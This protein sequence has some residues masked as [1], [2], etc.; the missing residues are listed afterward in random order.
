MLR[1]LL[2]LPLFASSLAFAQLAITPATLP[3][4][5]LDTTY[6]A[7]PGAPPVVASF[8]FIRLSV[9]GSS[10]PF[11]F[12]LLTGLLPPGLF[13]TQFGDLHGVP[14][15][16]GQFDFVVRAVS[17]QQETV[18]QSYSLLVLPPFASAQIAV[19]G[20][21]FVLPAQCEVVDSPNVYST[22]GS[23][24][25]GLSVSS[26]S[27]TIF[28]VPTGPPGQSTFSW[29]CVGD[30]QARVDFIFNVLAMPQ[31]SFSGQVGSFFSQ[32]IVFTGGTAPFF[33]YRVVSGE[34]PPG[35][36]LDASSGALTGLPTAEGDYSV[37]VQ[38]FD[39]FEDSFQVAIDIS[40]G[41][42]LEFS[43]VPNVMFLDSNRDGPRVSQTVRVTSG[44]TSDSFSMVSSTTGGG[45]WLSA[46]P[47]RGSTPAVVRI[48]ADPS[49]LPA[50]PYR[51][52]VDVRSAGIDGPS[53]QVQI[54]V[55]FRVVDSGPELSVAPR[56]IQASFRQGASPQQR[57]LD[58]VGAGAS[59]ILFSIDVSTENGGGWLSVDPLLGSVVSGD[60]LNPVVTLDP[61]G[62]PPGVYKGLITVSSPVAPDPAPIPV[63]MSVTGARG[64]LELSK[65]GM[66]FQVEQG[67]SP[68]PDFFFLS[69]AAGRAI[70]WQAAASTTSG[71]P[72]L[73]VSPPSGVTG[74]RASADVSVD[75][76]RLPPGW[77]FG[78][79]EA[80]AADAANSPQ[81]V[82]VAL[83]VA[84]RGESLPPEPS[85]RGMAFIAPPRLSTE[86]SRGIFVGNPTAGTQTLRISSSFPGN[87]IFFTA[88]V[89]NPRIPVGARV[90][91][92]V[93]VDASQLEAGTYRGFIDL[94]FSE[95]GPISRVEVLL[96]VSEGSPGGP[97][98][99]TEQG[100]P[101]PR[102]RACTPSSLEAVVLQPGDNFSAQRGQPVPIEAF[103][104]D[105]CG[106]VPTDAFVTAS[107]TN[108]DEP[109]QLRRNGRGGYSG[110]WAPIRVTPP[111]VPENEQKSQHVAQQQ[112]PD[113]QEDAQITIQANQINGIGGSTQVGG[114][115]S[116]AAG[117]P[118]ISPGGAVSAASFASSNPLPPGA[119]VSIFGGNLAPALAVAEELPLPSEL[120]TVSVTAAGQ[121]VALQFVSPRQINGVLPFGLGLDA[122]QQLVVRHGDAL[123]TPESVV[124]SQA[125]PAVFTQ[126]FSGAGPGI[127]VGV[128]P[129]GSQYLVSPSA[130]L[131]AGDVAV[132][133]CAGLGSV[134]QPVRASDAAPNSPLARTESVVTVTIGGVDAPVFYSGLAPGFAGLYQINAT[135]QAGTPTGDAVPL[136]LTA[137]GIRNPT[138]TV[139]VQ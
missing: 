133:Y 99:L 72:W 66:S 40:I 74:S 73:S 111:I 56:G 81:G 107:F 20:S 14:T 130:R 60:R 135:V 41:P 114:S 57:L 21:T 26:T 30:A 22:L 80:T 64:L 1:L 116:A 105:D 45:D 126:N 93:R 8:N 42:G 112:D 83:R 88:S 23:V 5:R 137:N 115:L 12:S 109:I 52:V 92:L 82:T 95:S 44:L 7:T 89:D 29:F 98:L 106:N 70:G 79:I 31:L 32:P 54:Q 129:D 75:T 104:V 102:Q 120:N 69:E 134:D 63:T 110:L 86:L 50:G 62:L 103:V 19:V 33:G 77:Y 85:D 38:R 76:S 138:V 13:L 78:R 65:A 113:D 100:A 49:G 25:A 47:A 131:S 90:P 55:Q 58:I 97:L 119:F 87:P 94:A 118:V 17:G 68:L 121:P 91:M 48:E 36:D 128:R 37:I 59:S 4:G 71:G 53:G 96:V 35:L 132:I 123:S 122:A 16:T 34:L 39:R 24:P 127:V 124:V 139:A 15:Q 84:P 51:G 67:S 117:I 9:S 61:T 125:Q 108:L 6:V 11:S 3:P 28:G 2:L 27:G 10:N 136:E 46:T 101:A 18:T 43:V